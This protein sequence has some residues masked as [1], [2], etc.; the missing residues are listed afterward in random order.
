MSAFPLGWSLSA[1][2][3]N[4]S[5]PGHTRPRDSISTAPRVTSPA[6]TG[7]ESDVFEPEHPYR[8][9][10]MV[11]WLRRSGDKRPPLRR[12]SRTQLLLQKVRGIH[13]SPANGET[14]E[15]H[16]ITNQ[17]VLALAFPSAIQQ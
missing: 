7:M 1:L 8:Q 13:G 5:S 3:R 14:C 11:W 16:N 2:L 12:S 9:P 17:Q 15:Q 6:I 10:H 4:R